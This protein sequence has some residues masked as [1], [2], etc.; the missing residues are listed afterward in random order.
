M[1]ERNDRD[2]QAVAIRTAM[3][4]AAVN[5]AAELAR[6]LGRPGPNGEMWVHRR[7]TG[8]VA[9]TTTDLAV[10]AR[11]LGCRVRDLLPEDG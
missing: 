2:P 4:Q 3:A 9:P 7:I 6:R 1:A 11:A 10:I 8:R 5:S